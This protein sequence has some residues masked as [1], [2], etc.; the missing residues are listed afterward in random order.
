MKGFASITLSTVLVFS[1]NCFAADERTT[2]VPTDIKGSYAADLIGRGLNSF[3]NEREDPCVA[4]EE[5]KVPIVLGG[6]AKLKFYAIAVSRQSDIFRASGFDN[7]VS[8]GYGPAGVDGNMK[9]IAS[10]RVSETHQTLAVVVE[11]ANQPLSLKGVH[12]NSRGQ[13]AQASKEKFYDMCGDSYI[14][15][16]ITGGRLVALFTLDTSTTKSKE[17]SDLVLKGHYGPS[18]EIS[19]TQ[20]NELITTLKSKEMKVQCDMEGGDGNIPLD[21]FLA[22]AAKFGSEV[23]AGGNNDVVIG[24]KTKLYRTVDGNQPFLADL[25]AARSTFDRAAD[26]AAEYGSRLQLIRD[27]QENDIYYRPRD[28]ENVVRPLA[29]LNKS[30]EDIVEKAKQC[31]KAPFDGCSYLAAF[32]AAPSYIAPKRILE[33]AVYIGTDTGNLGML[34]VTKNIRSLS[35]ELVGYLLTKEEA[36]ERHRAMSDLDKWEV[37]QEPAGARDPGR[38]WGRQTAP[39]ASPLAKKAIGPSAGWL[40]ILRA[41]TG[42]QPDYVEVSLIRIPIRNAAGDSYLNALSTRKEFDGILNKYCAPAD[43]GVTAQM[44]LFF[45]GLRPDGPVCWTWGGLVPPK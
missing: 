41:G 6:L 17:R 21:D 8:L 16:V 13:S 12:W 7:K 36:T 30:Y 24:F 28:V 22:R 25:D 4:F 11:A 34:S 15:S 43:P 37:F 3:S 23:R 33:N 1:H 14:D 38:L 39:N 35:S 10:S 19:S 42:G 2:S 27:V 20:F 32:P 5:T 18:N 44:R 31:V 29:D 9:N 40:D 26:R 45:P